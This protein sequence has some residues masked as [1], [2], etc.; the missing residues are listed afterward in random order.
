MSSNRSTAKRI[1]STFN[2]A[3]FL[4][5]VPTPLLPPHLNATAYPFFPFSRTTTNTPF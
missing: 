2:D 1:R 3:P 5:I 4:D